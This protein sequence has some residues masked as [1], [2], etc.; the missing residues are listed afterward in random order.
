[1]GL[2]SSLFGYFPPH[3]SLAHFRAHQAAVGP[4]SLGWWTLWLPSRSITGPAID[5]S[6]TRVLVPSL[7]RRAPLCGYPGSC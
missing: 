7:R 1:M 3:P 6:R 5:H 4:W 2:W